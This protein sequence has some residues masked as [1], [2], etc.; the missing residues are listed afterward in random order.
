[1]TNCHKLYHDNMS[2]SDVLVQLVTRLISVS[3]Y[4][5]MSAMVYLK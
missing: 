5:C 1:M 4:D 3:C 2:S